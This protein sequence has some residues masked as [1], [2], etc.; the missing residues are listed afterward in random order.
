MA[1]F[2]TLIFLTLFYRMQLYVFIPFSAGTRFA[3]CCILYVWVFL[4]Q[5]NILRLTPWF[6]VLVGLILLAGL[7]TWLLSGAAVAVPATSRFGNVLML[8]PL[9]AVLV[10][11]KKQLTK[12]FCLFGLIAACAYA[13]LLFQYFGGSLDILVGHYIA[14]RG[15][16][17]RYMTLVGEPNVG[18]MLAVLIFSIGMILIR[19]R[20][21]AIIVAGLAFTWVVFSI[22]KASM[23][24][25]V[26]SIIFCIFVSKHNRRE[27]CLRIVFAC[28]TGVMLLALIGGL[29]YG[30]VCVSSITGSITGEPSL[31]DDFE[32]RQGGGGGHAVSL[33]FIDSILSNALLT[34]PFNYVFGASYS[35][36]GSAAQEVLGPNAGV[37]LPHNSYVEL[38]LTGGISMLGLVLYLMLGAFRAL[39]PGSRMPESAEERCALVC[40]LL[41][42]SWMFVYPVIYE[43]ITG[44]LFWVIVGY[45]NRIGI[46]GNRFHR[47][48]LLKGGKN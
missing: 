1:G 9:A 14:I 27:V 15:N 25:I 33:S 2:S 32:S 6:F 21:T 7:H 24:G 11:G 23:I 3:L 28:F 30:K 29:E 16:L 12:V 22:S 38:L 45:G 8:G 43:P 35:L 5:K 31:L 40:L 36:V 42:S 37:V 4:I 26:L 39:V 19:S 34:R 18:G 47:L 46:Y 20:I 17:V 41:L 13:T 44:C 48:H 10:M